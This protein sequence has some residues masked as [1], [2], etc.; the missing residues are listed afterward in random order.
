MFRYKLSPK[1]LYPSQRFFTL[2][3]LSAL[4]V[5]G[6][7]EQTAIAVSA[8]QPTSSVS[9]I[10]SIELSQARP[11]PR[12]SRQIIRRVRL[13][14]SERFNVPRQSLKLI[15]FSRETWS[16]GCLGL[17][18]PNERCTGALVE[19]WRIEMTDG[20][21]NWVY[22][23]DL[24]AQ[25]IRPEMTVDAAEI[26]PDV[27]ETVLTTIAKQVRAPIATLRITESKAATWDGCMG[28]Y[29]PGRACTFIAIPGW[30][31]I[32]AGAKQ[33]WVYHINQD[34][35]Q[36][37][38][39]ATASS[40]MVPSFAT[41]D[42][43][44]YGQPESNIVFRAIEAGGLAGRVTERVLTSDGTLYR[45]VKQPN[46]GQAGSSGN[47]QGVAPVI[48]KRLSKN[49]VQQFQ[50]LLEAQR[51]PNLNNLRYLSD[52]A[53]A[54]YPTLTLQGMGSSVEY[55]DLEIDRLPTALRSVIQAWNGL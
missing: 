48:E 32:V 29:E 3:L 7:L 30:R 17:E 43:S 33:S 26:P 13:D 53:F 54:D 28:I 12:P 55:I 20:Q 15:S 34:G 45:Q 50:Q 35:T 40:S 22:R 4:L 24:T 1:K 46:Q 27:S 52:A 25:V 21:Q 6:A 14:L 16:N 9:S 31:I 51:F 42:E 36:I 39:N 38:Q 5:N 37:A 47:P 41:A 11:N 23:T 18:A 19:G 10:P 49:Q 2:A 8:K 44:P